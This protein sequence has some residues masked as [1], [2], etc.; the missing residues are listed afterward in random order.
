MVQKK[1]MLSTLYGKIRIAKISVD[2]GLF[3]RKHAAE[4]KKRLAFEHSRILNERP[5]THTEKE[6]GSHV[7][8]AAAAMRRKKEARN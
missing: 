3:V 8:A 4:I 5:L 2:F 1:R 6:Y 7:A